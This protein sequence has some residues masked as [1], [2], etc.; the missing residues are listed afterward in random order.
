[1]NTWTWSSGSNRLKC[2]FILAVDS[3]DSMCD[4]IGVTQYVLERSAR[5]RLLCEASTVSVAPRTLFSSSCHGSMQASAWF[6]IERAPC[7]REQGEAGIE[8]TVV[9][10]R[11]WL[12]IAHHLVPPAAPYRM[13]SVDSSLS[14][15]LHFSMSNEMFEM[16]RE[17][18][19]RE[20]AR[21]P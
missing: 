12:T 5:S 4:F 1:M 2:S 17:G 20:E 9:H 10:R 14:R 8:S 3:A 15:P 21:R 7:V 6:E 19:E 11:R 16:E 18:R 13:K